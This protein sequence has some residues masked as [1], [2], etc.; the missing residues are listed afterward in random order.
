MSITIKN[1]KHRH[2]HRCHKRGPTGFNWFNCANRTNQIS[3]TNWIGWTN[4][5]SWTNWIF[6]TNWTNWTNWITGSTGSN[7]P[8]GS[9]TFVGFAIIDITGGFTSV[10]PVCTNSALVTECC[11]RKWIPRGGGGG[12][13]WKFP[14]SVTAG[15]SISGVVGA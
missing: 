8:C 5:I 11:W 13:F 12:T 4:R 15:Q 14:V 2:K 1:T 10:A 9:S 6:R 7:G 3:G